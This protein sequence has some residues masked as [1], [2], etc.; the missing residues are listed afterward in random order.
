MLK[1]FSELRNQFFKKMMKSVSYAADMVLVNGITYSAVQI[2][3]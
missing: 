1:P 3:S 2:V